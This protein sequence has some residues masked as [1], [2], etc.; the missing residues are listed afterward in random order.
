MTSLTRLYILD[1]GLFQV[2]ENRRIIG[3]PGY[4]IQTVDGQNILVDTGFPVKYWEDGEKA[5]REDNLGSFGQILSLNHDNFPAGQLAKLGLAP[6]DI[7]VLILTHSHID[8]VG[9][10]A[11]FSS[12]VMGKAEREL[13]KPLYFDGH[14]PIAW[15]KAS[16][17]L[18]EADTELLPGLH[19]LLTPGHSPGHLSLLLELPNTRVLLTA[20]A[21]SRAEEVKQGFAGSWNPE[22]AQHQA[23]RIL[24]LA[25][26]READVIYGHDPEQWPVLRKAPQPYN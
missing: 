4:L 12:I 20:D 23:R 9:G 10:I 6:A 19:L 7:S 18:I 13:P 11:D 3:I 16:Y 26:T 8:H 25:K 2:Y 17:R 15:P 24:A 5:A 1:F 21:I 14:S 22:L